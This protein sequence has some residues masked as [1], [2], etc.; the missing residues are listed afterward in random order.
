[1]PQKEEVLRT[2]RIGLFVP[3]DQYEQTI[4]NRLRT[5]INKQRAKTGQDQ[6][7]LQGLVRG[8]VRDYCHLVLGQAVGTVLDKPVE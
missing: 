3:F 1:M 8:M 7:T 2:G 4:L 5:A 6:L